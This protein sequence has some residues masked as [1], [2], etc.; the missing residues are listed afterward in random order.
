MSITYEEALTT[1]ES[2]FGAPWTRE[3]LDL[4]LRHFQGHMENTV[5]S[6]LSHGEGA[7][8]D[9]LKKLTNQTS[10]DSTTSVATQNDQELAR[11]LAR[12]EQDQQAGRGRATAPASKN[13]KGRG[14]DTDLPPAFLRIP[15]YKGRGGQE[16]GQV[17]DQDE[18]LARMLQD[19][20][21]SQELANNPEFAHLARSRNNGAGRGAA[22][23]RSGRMGE[24]PKRGGRTAAAGPQFDGKKI[25][26]N[27]TGTCAVSKN[28]DT[29]L[30]EIEWLSRCGMPVSEEICMFEIDEYFDIRTMVLSAS[31]LLS[32]PPR[33]ARRMISSRAGE[34]S[35]VS[36]FRIF[37]LLFL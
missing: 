20:L 30:L 7:P 15:G 12:Q 10:L 18:A 9:L 24:L 11:Q 33:T 17:M 27:I 36:N 2:M 26:K 4:V 29:R 5:E 21:F 19:E 23:H 32:A 14:T 16:G 13:K 25:M 37:G 6:I 34:F 1:L 31:L 3:S 22:Q 35:R 8:D 28:K